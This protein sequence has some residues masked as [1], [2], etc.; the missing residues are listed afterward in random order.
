MTRGR[1]KLTLQDKKLCNNFPII[2][3]EIY[4]KEIELNYLVKPK[5]LKVY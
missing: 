3:T 1:G 2:L 5:S 4:S